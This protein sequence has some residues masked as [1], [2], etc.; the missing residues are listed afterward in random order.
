M[1]TSD[2]FTRMTGFRLA[3]NY[4]FATVFCALFGAVYEHFSFGV[5]SYFMLYA[6]AFPLLL[7]ALPFLLAGLRDKYIHLPG[8]SR[9]LWHAG[10]ATLTVG[11][12]FRGV[13]EIY[14]TDSVLCI[15]YLAAGAV[16]LLSGAMSAVFS[17]KAE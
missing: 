2:K 13:I 12:L 17:R 3:R 14:G 16:L 8:F 5:Y 11:S 15:V 6:F 7:G 1:S 9:A 4:L 10:T